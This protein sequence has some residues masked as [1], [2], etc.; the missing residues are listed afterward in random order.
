NVQAGVSVQSGTRNSILSNAIYSN[1]MLG[2]DLVAAGDPPSGVTPN[3]PGVRSGPND[4]QNYPV[5]TTLTSDG[6]VTHVVGTL[7]SLPS[8]TFLVQFFASTSADPSGYGEGERRFHS[9]QVTTDAAGNAVIDVTL[10]AP[11]SF[12]TLLSA[13]A[14]NLAIGDTSEFSR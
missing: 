4:L 10:P 9:T 13:T 3:Q 7:N 2:I 14:T 11:W 12:G 8:T 6:T 1:G 5:L